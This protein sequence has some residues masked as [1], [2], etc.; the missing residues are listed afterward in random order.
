LAV[1]GEHG[2]GAVPE[3]L[4][5]ADQAAGRDFPHG[6]DSIG[7]HPLGGYND[8][9]AADRTADPLP[10]GDT[11]EI[12]N[13]LAG[14]AV[15]SA[16]SVSHAVVGH[17]PQRVPAIGRKSDVVEPEVVRNMWAAGTGEAGLAGD[18]GGPR[19]PQDDG[20]LGVHRTQLSR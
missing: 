18:G 19:G 8:G 1:G 2:G 15:P 9:L 11:P 5:R 3:P 20:S 17:S 4:E 10:A 14:A 12:A 6:Q 16:R 7:P 13:H